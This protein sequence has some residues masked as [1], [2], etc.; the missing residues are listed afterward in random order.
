MYTHVYVHTYRIILDIIY[1]HIKKQYTWVL[2]ASSHITCITLCPNNG[3][4]K[5][6]NRLKMFITKS[7]CRPPVMSNIPIWLAYKAVKMF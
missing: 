6:Y 3:K 2:Y 7:L 5:K 1:I 4:Q